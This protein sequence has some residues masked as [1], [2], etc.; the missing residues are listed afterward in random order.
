[1]SVPAFGALNVSEFVTTCLVAAA[2]E[3]RLGGAVLVDPT[4][5]QAAETLAAFV[6]E[7]GVAVTKIPV[8]IDRV[9]LLGGLATEASIGEGRVMQRAGLL[10]EA[11]ALLLDDL[12][13]WPPERR[14]LLRRAVGTT[15]VVR[16]LFAGWSGED[17]PPMAF[18]DAVAF[19]IPIRPEPP[20]AE[21]RLHTLARRLDGC[22][23][24]G[25]RDLAAMIAQAKSDLPRV[26]VDQAV[27]VLAADACA[28][29]VEGDRAVIHAVHAARAHAAIHRR[30]EITEADLEFARLAVFASRRNPDEAPPPPPQE[31]E[32]TEADESRND[33]G[34][35]GRDGGGRGNDAP[36]EMEAPPDA[37]PGLPDLPMTRTVRRARRRPGGGE[38][39]VHDWDRG[40]PERIVDRRP[41]A[42]RVA[43]AA[44]LRRAAIR[45]G[46]RPMKVRPEDLRYW[47]FRRKAGRLFIIAV[48]ASGSMAR[49]RIREAKGVVVELLSEAY[50]RRDRVAVIVARGER[51]EVLVPPTSSVAR[52]RAL[53]ART[54]VGGG[55]PLASTLDEMRRV[56][57]H[58]RR[59][60]A[61]DPLAV[62][63]TDGRANVAAHGDDVAADLDAAV[64]RFLRDAMPCV[65]VDTSGPFSGRD[66]ASR[67]AERMGADFYALPPGRE[68]GELV[69]RL[70]FRQPQSPR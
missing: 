32:G 48:D 21:G 22:V 34:G 30:D 25:E 19:I 37:S 31:A 62:L 7:G 35:E 12:A 61:R 18:L 6:A 66:E 15:G 27:T 52:A 28:Q 46:V 68:G 24:Q 5:L 51:A 60:D 58:A 29:G 4:G 63:L 20:D 50:R 44:T 57:D 16:P 54:P 56:A 55:T 69:K 9:R 13:A 10:D 11:R 53:M 43:L 8:S 65:V 23:A 17:A 45:G 40:S 42:R 14:A 41:G 49:H 26:R 47:R 3:P 36:T 39:R 64:D 2:A 70:G 33:P 38:A 67:L 1:M 59:R